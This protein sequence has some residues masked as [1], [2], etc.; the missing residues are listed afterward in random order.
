MSP[1][2]IATYCLLLD[3][4]NAGSG[5]LAMNYTISFNDANGVTQYAPEAIQ[6]PSKTFNDCIRHNNMS[7]IGYARIVGIANGTVGPY[8]EIKLQSSAGKCLVLLFYTKIGNFCQF[9]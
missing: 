6:G 8:S 2:D 3:W 1:N 9:Q 7:S 5:D 4:E